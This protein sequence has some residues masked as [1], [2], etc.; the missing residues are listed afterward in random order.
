MF[1]YRFE[2]NG[3]LTTKYKGQFKPSTS[4]NR[5]GGRYIMTEIQNSNF[6]LEISIFFCLFLGIFVKQKYTTLKMVWN[7]N[8]EEEFCSMLTKDEFDSFDNNGD[9]SLTLEEFLENTRQNQ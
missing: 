6:F 2:C 5:E 3:W 9:G 1:F 7:V 4:Q 8:C